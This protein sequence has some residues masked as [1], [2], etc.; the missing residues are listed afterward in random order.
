MRAKKQGSLKTAFDFERNRDH[1][2]YRDKKKVS[3]YPFGH[4]KTIFV[5][6]ETFRENFD[7]IFSKGGEAN[8][9]TKEGQEEG[10]G[11]L[12]QTDDA[13]PTR[14]AESND[15]DHDDTRRKRK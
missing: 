10:Q 3:I 11:L 14:A 12:S 8:G 9:E 13:A 2:A 6:G 15:F 5:A 4:E 1:P 7:R